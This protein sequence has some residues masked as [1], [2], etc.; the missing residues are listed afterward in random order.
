MHVRDEY[1]LI[2]MRGHSTHPKIRCRTRAPVALVL[3]AA[4]VCASPRGARACAAAETTKIV[5]LVVWATDPNQGDTWGAMPVFVRVCPDDRHT[6]WVLAPSITWNSV[7]RLTGTVR[8]YAYLRPDETLTIIASASTRINYRLVAT[9]QRLPAQTGAWTDE[10]AIR[11][12]RSAFAR[13]FGLGLA[14]QDRDET[15]YTAG[16]ML[17]TARRGLN[18]GG[19]VNFGVLTGLERDGVDD[20]GVRGLPLA[21]DVYPGVPGMAGASQAW[22]GVDLRYD[23]RAGLDYA[24]RGMRLDGWAAVVEGIE[25]SPTYVRGGVEGRVIIPELPWLSGAARVLW[26]AVSADDAPFYQQS[27]LGGSFL[28]R[29]FQEGRFVAR[30]AWTV[31]A[32]QRLRLLRTHFFGVVADWRLDP[33]VAAG[34][35]FDRAADMFAKPQLAAGVGLRAFVHPN[36]VGRIDLA[37]GGEG[38]KAYVEIGYPY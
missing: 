11:I 9:W 37:S 17:M 20:E 33:F 14:T 1:F 10:A 12:E 3:A 32:E 2:S 36:L 5:P 13:F 27:S 19:H 18:V 28:L 29:G 35:V 6:A 38:L 21:P 31:E 24:E 15:S 8:W 26:T 34:Q 23:D 4:L 30:Q 25:R 7:I 22:Q 16:R